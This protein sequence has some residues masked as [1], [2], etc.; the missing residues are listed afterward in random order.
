M[1]FYFRCFTSASNTFVGWWPA[2]RYFASHFGK[3]AAFEC[4]TNNPYPFISHI[5]NWRQMFAIWIAWLLTT[6]QGPPHSFTCFYLSFSWFPTENF[7]FKRSSLRRDAE[8]DN[9]YTWLDRR[10][11]LSMRRPNGNGMVSSRTLQS[12]MNVVFHEWTTSL[13]AILALPLC[14]NSNAHCTIW[15]RRLDS[16]HLAVDCTDYTCQMKSS[17]GCKVL[18][19]LCLWLVHVG[20]DSPWK[21]VILLKRASRYMSALAF[22]HL[23]RSDPPTTWPESGYSTYSKAGRVAGSLTAFTVTSHFPTSVQT[24]SQRTQS[25]NGQLHLLKE[26]VIGTL[27]SAPF[28]KIFIQLDSGL[29]ENVQFEGTSA[30][31]AGCCDQPHVAYLLISIVESSIGSDPPNQNRAR[32]CWSLLPSSSFLSFSRTDQFQLFPSWSTYSFVSVDSHPVDP[33]DNQIDP[34]GSLQNLSKKETKNRREYFEIGSNLSASS[35]VLFPLGGRWWGNS[36]SFSRFRGRS[37]Y[38][39]I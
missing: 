36:S 29:G 7:K 24:D 18:L 3:R 6:E 2:V 31:A 4:Y 34:A 13:T 39:A 33:V 15:S 19:S 5:Q 30:I 37:P 16:F 25:L 20:R 26:I 38:P 35:M 11:I 28:T 23:D 1:N 8:T 27:Q 22:I 12:M 10:S 9:R 14:I 17:T 32:Q 21:A